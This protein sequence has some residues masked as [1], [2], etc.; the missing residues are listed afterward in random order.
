MPELAPSQKRTHD[1]VHYQHPSQHD[2]QQCSG[3]KHFIAA[4]PPRCEGVRSPIRAED[5]CR[6]FA[7]KPDLAK[8]GLKELY[9]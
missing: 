7:A 4:N 5:W 6:R 9:G 2:G 1:D 8:K 3:C